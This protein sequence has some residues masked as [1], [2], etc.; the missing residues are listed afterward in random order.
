V[1]KGF[2]QVLVGMGVLGGV[3]LLILIFRT[4]F[5]LL[6][7]VHKPVDWQEK[8]GLALGLGLLGRAVAILLVSNYI[9]KEFWIEMALAAAVLT[10]VKHAR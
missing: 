10:H 4:P 8:L 9:M 6:G 2:V 3:S 7:K 1:Q 5:R